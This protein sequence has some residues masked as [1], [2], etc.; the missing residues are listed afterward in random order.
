MIFPSLTAQK[1]LRPLIGRLARIN[2]AKHH[3]SMAHETGLKQ[4]E[5]DDAALF[6]R[7]IDGMFLWAYFMAWD[8]ADYSQMFHLDDPALPINRRDLRFYHKMLQRNLH[9]T[10]KERVL[11]K[12]FTFTIRIKTVLR[13]YPD[14]RLIYLVR[15]PVSV[16]PSGMSLISGVLEQQYHIDRLDP[17][18]RQRYYDRIYEGECWLYKSFHDLYTSGQVPEENLLVVRFPDL[19]QDLAG[20]MERIRAF[21]GLTFSP[22]YLQKI[23]ETDAKQKAYHS[24]HSYDLQRFGLSEQRIREDLSFVYETFDL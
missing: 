18:V 17:A 22:G 1:L 2:P 23:A 24:K 11:G 13:R 14:A 3:K 16:I 9:K 4:L 19:M 10:G 15:D 5:T 7:Y 8:E 20:T 21:T 12:W 6:L